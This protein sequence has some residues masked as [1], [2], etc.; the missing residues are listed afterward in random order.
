MQLPRRITALINKNTPLTAEYEWDDEDGSVHYWTLWE[1]VD[2]DE[3]LGGAC[4]SFDFILA[5]TE[6]GWAL[7]ST[8]EEPL[9]DGR[10]MVDVPAALNMYKAINAYIRQYVLE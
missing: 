6:D 9:C 4:G 8:A 5:V 3:S 10:G 2:N 7:T 1:H